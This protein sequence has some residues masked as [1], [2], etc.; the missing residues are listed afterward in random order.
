MLHGVLG[1]KN[2]CSLSELKDYVGNLYFY[3]LN[4]ATQICTQQTLQAVYQN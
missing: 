4:L 2:I 1:T 3:L